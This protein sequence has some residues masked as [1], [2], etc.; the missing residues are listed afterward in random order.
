MRITPE[1]QKIL[2]QIYENRNL[3]GRSKQA[4]NDTVKNYTEFQ[5]ENMKTLI[6]EAITEEENGVRW[7]N[8]QLRQRLIN[9]RTYLYQKYRK[10]TAHIHFTR[11]KS[12]YKHYEIEIHS[13]PPISTRNKNNET[14]QYKD[15]PDREILQKAI[16]ISN[17][18]MKAI[19][20][21]MASSGCGRTET[22][23]L[24]IQDFINSTSEYH[25]KE[26]I[27]DVIKALKNREDIVPVWTL[28]RQKTNK[29][30]TTFNTP[31]ATQNIINYLISR[32]DPYTNESKLFKIHYMHL[33]D[34]FIELNQK[35]KLGKVGAYNRLRCHMLRKY[36]ASQLYNDG[37]SMDVVDSLQG[38]GKTST[39]NSYFMEN[40]AKL[41]EQYMEHLD[42]VTIDAEVISVKSPEYV[43]L[44]MK[45][46]EKE[47]KIHDYEKLINN[48]DERLRRIE[49]N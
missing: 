35:L 6:E 19:I 48:I 45:V 18:L 12:L 24:T 25:T 37:L 5:K 9:Y 41:K 43:K 29:P 34:T 49:E 39:R 3:Q 13:L 14:I 26:D 44:E 23:N 36:H 15:L 1:D 32:T 11:I 7:R 2:N 8:R 33:N 40:P 21:F 27:H 22:L 30:Y 28:T 47:E 16:N 46:H 4:Y 31:E 20:T 38:R 42:S 17:P 10:N